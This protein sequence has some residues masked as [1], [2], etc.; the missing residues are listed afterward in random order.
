[1]C[2]IVPRTYSHYPK[3]QLLFCSSIASTPIQEKPPTKSFSSVCCWRHVRAYM[4]CPK[5]DH[6]TVSYKNISICSVKYPYLSELKL[7]RNLG[8]TVLQNNRMFMEQ[9]KL[10]QRI[11]MRT[12]CFW[13]STRVRRTSCVLFSPKPTYLCNAEFTENGR[14]CVSA[15]H[16]STINYIHNLIIRAKL[17]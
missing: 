5:Y 6:H 3:Q 8:W 4:S 10:W 14:I 9:L 15:Y 17:S 7:N 13:I 16:C 12:S 11:F 1:M 2:V